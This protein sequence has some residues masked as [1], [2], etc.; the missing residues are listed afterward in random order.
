MTRLRTTR[1]DARAPRGPGDG[2]AGAP[3]PTERMRKALRLLGWSAHTGR[4]RFGPKAQVARWGLGA[5]E[6]PDDPR[7]FD[8][9]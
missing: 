3:E 6:L 7:V 2:D 1:S 8:G 9:R 5:D 4:P